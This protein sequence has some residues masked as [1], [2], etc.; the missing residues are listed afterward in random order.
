MPFDWL[1][2]GDHSGSAEQTSH[3]AQDLTTRWHTARLK[4]R[5]QSCSGATYV[6]QHILMGQGYPENYRLSGQGALDGDSH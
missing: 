3:S 2:G 6:L 5:Q 4:L 1:R